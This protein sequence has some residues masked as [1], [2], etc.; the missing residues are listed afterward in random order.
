M[1]EVTVK[2]LAEDI[3]APVE[4]L[5]AQIKNA[6]LSQRQ[7][8]DFVSDVEK[9]E[10][11]THLKRSHGET[12][13]EPKKITLKRKTTSTL[14]FHATLTAPSPMIYRTSMDT[15]AAAFPTAIST[16]L[17]GTGGSF[18]ACV[19]SYSSRSDA[20]VTAA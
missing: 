20:P 4:R 12:D 19:R 2:Q 15:C 1:S 6:G 17:I 10:L 14:T 3:G 8:N 13:S 16:T 18:P 9:K 5:L 7:E 11:L